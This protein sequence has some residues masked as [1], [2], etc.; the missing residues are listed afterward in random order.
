MHRFALEAIL[1][2]LAKLATSEEFVGSLT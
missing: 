1:P 2:Q